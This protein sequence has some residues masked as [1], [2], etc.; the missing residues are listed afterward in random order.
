[1]AGGQSTYD[2]HGHI[3]TIATKLGIRVSTHGGAVVWVLR[4]TDPALQPG[5]S[6]PPVLD[7]DVLEASTN[8]E[9]GRCNTT[10]ARLDVVNRKLAVRSRPFRQPGTGHP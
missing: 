8:N 5:A 3:P 6:L 1:M 7:A 4:P 9:P 2:V 10:Y